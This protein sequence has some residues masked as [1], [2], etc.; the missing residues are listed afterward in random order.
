MDTV[1]GV[2]EV[3]AARADDSYTGPVSIDT[4]FPFGDTTPSQFYVSCNNIVVRAMFMTFNLVGGHKWD[5]F[6]WKLSL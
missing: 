3:V 2:S 6:L 4:N 1:Y 5:S